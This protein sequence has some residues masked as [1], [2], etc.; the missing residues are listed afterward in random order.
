MVTS[1]LR[2]AR[3]L[4]I[5]LAFVHVRLCLVRDR[6]VWARNCAEM[7]DSVRCVAVRVHRRNAYGAY[8]LLASLQLVRCEY[9]LHSDCTDIAGA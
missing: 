7:V 5:E 2:A 4:A 1:S 6:G 8:S 9:T 3:V